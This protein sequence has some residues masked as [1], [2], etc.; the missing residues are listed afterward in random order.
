[1][2]DSH[3]AFGKVDLPGFKKANMKKLNADE[4]KSRRS[5]LK[6]MVKK[7]AIPVVTVYLVNKTTPKLFAREP[8]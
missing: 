3:W 4:L 1:L 8:E 5:F 6:G 2:S 7:A